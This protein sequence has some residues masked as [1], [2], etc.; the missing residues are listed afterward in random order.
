MMTEVAQYSSETKLDKF[1]LMNKTCSDNCIVKKIDHSEA[2]SELLD[3]YRGI[4]KAVSIIEQ[5]LY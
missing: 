1:P 3:S 5:Q 2:Q 4:M